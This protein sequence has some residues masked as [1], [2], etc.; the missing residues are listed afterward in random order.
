ME[1]CPGCKINGSP[2]HVVTSAYGPDDAVAALS[3][4]L[5]LGGGVN[6]NDQCD[7]LPSDAQFF[8]ATY[9]ALSPALLSRY[10]QP[11][12]RPEASL[13]VILVVNYCEDDYSPG[14][15]NDY[16]NAF[17]GIKGVQNARQFSLSLLN[18]YCGIGQIQ[19][20]PVMVQLTGGVEA[21]LENTGTPGWPE[22][23][24]WFWQQVS[25]QW[26]EYPLSG[27]PVTAPLT[28][29]VS[30]NGVPVP[31]MQN[32]IPQWTYD[33]Q[34]NAVAFLSTAAPQPG[35]A[36]DISYTLTCP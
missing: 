13:A 21:D 11:F 29:T 15:I 6:C 2:V 16:Y 24:A 27:T 28:I 5:N 23:L 9:R 26:L 32:G 30:E 18:R 31:Q 12:Y 14:T 25:L 4:L 10:N 20:L 1:P 36:V 8:E 7:G 34:T 3:R 19:R 22:E 33:A 17:I 35:D